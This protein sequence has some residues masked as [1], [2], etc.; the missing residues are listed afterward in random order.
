MSKKQFKGIQM[1]LGAAMVSCAAVLVC[2]WPSDTHADDA[3]SAAAEPDVGV[4]TTKMGA[5]QATTRLVQDDKVKGKWYVEVKVHNTSGEGR[6]ALEV[7][8]TLEKTVFQPMMARG[9]PVPSKVWQAKDKV[10]VLPNETVTVRHALP[11][12]LNS[13]VSASLK[14][15]KLDKQGNP[16]MQSTTMFATSVGKAT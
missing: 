2:A 16:V 3:E 1:M 13:Q 5:L 6:E 8:E 10:E 7:A 14:A 9:G 12:W 4:D 15:P 11:A